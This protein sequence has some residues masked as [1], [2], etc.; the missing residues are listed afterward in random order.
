MCERCK[1]LEGALI[2]MVEQYLPASC[3]IDGRYTHNFMS[4]GEHTLRLMAKLGIMETEDD[5]Y[6]TFKEDSP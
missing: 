1:K 2:V 5:V 4:A 6:Y 3:E